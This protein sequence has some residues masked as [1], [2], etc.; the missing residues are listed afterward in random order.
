MTTLLVASAGGHLKQLHRLRPRIA[1]LGTDV[2]WVT[3]EN[4]QTRSL[5]ADEQVV[6]VRETAP[7]DAVTILRN[8]DKAFA[9]LRKHRIRA[10]VSTGSQVV[11]PFIAM[12]RA[13]GA[14][15]HFIESAARSGGG[16][17]TGR[18]V[19]RFP[20][21]RYYRQYPNLGATYVGSVFD[22]FESVPLEHPP[23][24]I[25][26][27]VVVLGTMPNHHFTRLLDRLVPMIGSEAETLWQVGSTDTSRH[28]IDAHV[29]V[30][31]HD[32]VAAMRDAD[33]VIAHA[34]VGAALDALEAG[35]HPVLVPRRLA[36]GEHIDDHQPQVAHALVAR[37]LATVRDADALGYEDLIVAAGR[38]VVEV[39]PEAINL[40]W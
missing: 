32:L 33:V 19:R 2:I 14:S 13:S 11:I 6:Y 18:L 5:L 12:A 8:T 21:V 1:D 31:A 30:P 15:C 29:S 34:G 24:A 17:L 27:A 25:K 20:G 23:T 36:H 10:L 35:R 4:A 16:S 37:G 38:T 9:V 3:W 7:R 40:R 26:R 39:P 28:N 22:G